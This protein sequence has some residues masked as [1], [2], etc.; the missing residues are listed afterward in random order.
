MRRRKALRLI[1][2]SALV[3][4][5][6]G[7]CAQTDNV[8]SGT[9]PASAAYVP[10]S[11]DELVFEEG[12]AVRESPSVDRKPAP[13]SLPGASFR[14]EISSSQYNVVQLRYGDR[15]SYAH[16]ESREAQIRGLV[17]R[18]DRVNSS[19]AGHVIV[20][21]YSSSGRLMKYRFVRS[22]YVRELDSIILR[23]LASLRFRV[24][25]NMPST[26]YITYVITV[27]RNQESDASH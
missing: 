10:D 8:P 14:I 26:I 24:R 13:A 18:Y 19:R 16:D 9:A 17:S 22:T 3:A 5:T 2:Q 4:L 7:A 21:V 1:I 20:S 27:S 12:D 6:V 25:R 23:D 11:V 15:I